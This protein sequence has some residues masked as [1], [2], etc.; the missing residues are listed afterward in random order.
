MISRGERPHFGVRFDQDGRWT[1]GEARWLSVFAEDR[2][3]AQ[4][5]ATLTIGASGGF[6]AFLAVVLPADV[7]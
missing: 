7:A 5:A 1:V 6:T 4:R 2:R 3:E